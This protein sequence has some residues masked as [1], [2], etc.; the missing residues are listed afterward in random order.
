MNNQNL[1][2]QTIGQYELV[3]LL[4]AGGMGAVYRAVQISLGR[5]VALKVLSAALANEPGYLERFNREARV[6]AALEHDHIV[7]VYDFGAQQDLTYVVMRLLTGGSLDSRMRQRK[8]A[9]PSM[10]EAVT[11]LNAMASALD[12][13][14]SRGV[15]HRDIKPANIMF[16][17]NGKPYLV[18]FGIAKILDATGAGLTGTGMAMGSP[19][20]MPPEQWRG[21][22]ATPASDQY[23]LAVTVYSMLAGRPPFEATSTPALMYKHFHDQPE[24]LKNFRQDVP[25]SLMH[26]L[27]KAMAKDALD[28]FGSVSEF[29]NAFQAAVGATPGEATG[30][31]TFPVQR[32]PLPTARLTP[33]SSTPPRTTPAGATPTSSGTTP[34]PPTA[35]GPVPNRPPPQKR[36]PLLVILGGVAVIAVLIAGALALFGGGDATD[37][38]PAPTL[39][40][41]APLIAD[42]TRTP[43]PTAAD[44]L[45]PEDFARATR[46]AQLTIQAELTALAAVD[47]TE[48]ASVWT[49][50]NTATYTPTYT[51][52]ATITN[53]ATH[54]ATVTPTDTLTATSTPSETVTATPTDTATITPSRTF[55]ATAS[56]T[57]SAT[58]PPSPLPTSA[59]DGAEIAAFNGFDNPDSGEWFGEPEDW[60]ELVDGRLIL[61]GAGEDTYP[62]VLAPWTIEENT[63]ILLEFRRPERGTAMITLETGEWDTPSY[64]SFN[65]YNDPDLGSRWAAE[66]FSGGT[67]STFAT[68]NLT[69][70]NAW[71]VLSMRIERVGNFTVFSAQMWLRDNPERGFVLDARHARFLADRSWQFVV[72]VS[73]GVIEIDSAL[74]LRYEDTAPRLIAPPGVTP[75]ATL[76]PTPRPTATPTFTPAPLPTSAIDGAEVVA[77]DGFDDSGLASWYTDPPGWAESGDGVLRL[78]EVGGDVYAVIRPPWTIT[79]GEGVLIAFKQIERGDLAFFIDH[80]EWDTLSYRRFGVSS[81]GDL[82]PY[83]STNVIVSSTWNTISQSQPIASDRWYMLLIRIHDDATYTAQIW[84]RDNP[85]RGFR[86]DARRIFNFVPGFDSKDWIVNLEIYRG[87]LE[88][89]SISKMRFADD[90]P[91]LIAPPGVTPSATLTPTPRPTAMPTET[92]RPTLIPAVAR[93]FEENFS[94]DQA[95]GITRRLGGHWEIRKIDGN[96][97]YCNVGDSSDDFDLIVFGESSWDNYIVEVDVRFTAQSPGALV[98]L[99]GRYDGSD[100]LNAYRAYFDRGGSASLGYYSPERNLGG[101]GYTIEANRWYTLQLEMV[102][103]RLRYSIDGQRVLSTF[104]DSR[105]EGLAGVLVHRGTQACIDNVRVWLPAV[106]PDAITVSVFTAAGSVNLRTGPATTFPTAGVAHTG[107][108]LTAI[109]RD[110]STRW[111]RVRTRSGTTAWI[112]AMLVRP[113]GGVLVDIHDLPVMSP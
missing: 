101:V 103:R 63:G 7:P 17:Q 24:P 57:A 82:S 56:S 81:A 76:T 44:T 40:T 2:G 98:E 93:L 41:A 39:T 70:T 106:P 111:L 51:A 55:T 19:Y 97:A 53:T 88:I 31:F 10:N 74:K 65:V 8:D 4:G 25:E 83:W 23:A 47:L 16:D 18:D 42:V 14:H 92:P 34:P 99:Y 60:A 13:A 73:T 59:I 100:A 43:A 11:L 1:A 27:V 72:E 80:D 109:G 113:L 20:Y 107:D 52:S 5:E 61:R 48:T 90:A 68:S 95:D 108:F 112:A 32:T 45:R 102:G 28:R 12:Y 49:A 30:F 15:I 79:D 6:S 37:R 54:T 87:A 58:P 78:S 69:S 75:S 21:E 35:S 38:T 85:E 22:N 71:Y 91:A 110:A 36:S 84:E 104:D 33:A 96:D 67:G 94:D 66:T 62:Y 26:V 50:T 86:L 46:N 3:E 64:R 29:A 105:G 89:D 9:K 77:F